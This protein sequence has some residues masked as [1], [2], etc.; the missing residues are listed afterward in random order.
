[1][2]QLYK[3]VIGHLIKGIDFF[4]FTSL[5][6]ACS[7][8][9]LCMATE[10]LILNQQ[11]TLGSSLHCFIFGSVLVVYNLHYLIKKSAKKQSLQY[12]WVQKNRFWNLMFFFTGL[13]LCFVFVLKLP[14]VIW[15]ICIFLALCSLAYS[16]P[17]LPFKNKPR[18]KDFGSIKSIV[19][20][21]VWTATTVVLPF[22]FYNVPFLDLYFEI[23]RRALFLFVLCLV[24]DI[25]DKEVDIDAGIKTIPNQIGLNKTYFIIRG[26]LLAYVFFA[27]LLFF[28]DG[29]LNRLLVH[30]IAVIS[31]YL[32]IQF[33]RNN[34]S[35]RNYIL[36]IDG[37]MF[38]YGWMIIFI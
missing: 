32:A 2:T 25:R 19:L 28:Y 9:T 36:F 17:I 33:V 34:S 29:L 27:G 18:I 15:Q 10:K 24:F 37:Q 30:L 20:V 21:T 35:D 23:A 7:A 38:L 1:M 3:V 11:S 5:F 4:L 26:L 16:L 22:Y 8:V 13:V 6:A 31:T 12:N 14:I